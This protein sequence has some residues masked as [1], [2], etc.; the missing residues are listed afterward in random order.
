MESEPQSSQEASCLSSNHWIRGDASLSTQSLSLT[1][2][3]CTLT[4]SSRMT[5]GSARGSQLTPW[6][7]WK[8][9]HSLHRHA[10]SNLW[11]GMLKLNLAHWSTTHLA[12]H[13]SH[14]WLSVTV[15]VCV[16]RLLVSGGPVPGAGASLCWSHGVSPGQG[17]WSCH[18]GGLCP[19]QTSQLPA[20]LAHTL[21]WERLVE[22]LHIVQCWVQRN[23]SI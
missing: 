18:S 12:L 5:V 2:T 3:V 22:I 20:R 16:S 14:E 15:C 21:Q 6:C 1:H 23:C 4:N 7:V 9:L 19:P 8:W 11:C 17:P 10:G 13:A